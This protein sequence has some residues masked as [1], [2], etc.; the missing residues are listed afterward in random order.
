M[1]IQYCRNYNEQTYLIKAR[2]KGIQISK[3]IVISGTGYAGVHAAKKL[4]LH[5]L[6]QKSR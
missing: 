6:S 5:Y 3:K 4:A 2:R 1:H